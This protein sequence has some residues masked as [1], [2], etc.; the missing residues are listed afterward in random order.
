MK[1]T[2]ISAAVGVGLACAVFFSVEAIERFR[3]AAYI[4]DLQAQVPSDWFEVTDLTVID[5]RNRDGITLEPT[6]R[7]TIWPRRLVEARVAVSSRNVQ[8][9]EPV[10]VGGTVTFIL[11]PGD[12]ITTTRPLSRLAGV[13]HCDWPIGEYRSRFAW[14]ITDP[15]TRVVKT[16]MQESAV[17]SVRP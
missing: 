8:S 1:K 5:G 16:I 11:E 3:Q 14:T 2:L 7:Q 13:D 10:C 6:V 17:F 9:G 4:A 15:A 12:P